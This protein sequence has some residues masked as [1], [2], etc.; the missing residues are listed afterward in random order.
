MLVAFPLPPAVRTYRTH[1]P[2]L[3]YTH[4]RFATPHSRITLQRHTVTV[5]LPVSTHTLPRP[6]APHLPTTYL[7]TLVG[8]YYLLPAGRRSG[9]ADWL[10]TIW[11]RSAVGYYGSLD[12]L[13]AGSTCTCGRSYAWL[14]AHY[15]LRLHYA[16]TPDWTAR[17]HHCLP[18]GYV[19]H[20]ARA[21]LDSVARRTV[22]PPLRATVCA[23]CAFW[24]RGFMYWRSALYTAHAAGLRCR[25]CQDLPV[26]GLP[27]S[28]AG[29]VW[30]RLPA[31]FTPYH[32]LAD[33][34]RF[35]R[36]PT[37][38]LAA[39]V[40]CQ[41]CSSYRLLYGWLHSCLRTLPA[42]AYATYTCLPCRGPPLPGRYICY[43]AVLLPACLC[44][45]PTACLPTMP[46]RHG[47]AMVK[48]RFVH[49]C[50]PACL[51]HHR[52]R[53]AR[54]GSGLD[55]ACRTRFALDYPVH[56]IPPFTFTP[57]C[58]HTPT[59]DGRF[60]RLS[61]YAYSTYRGLRLYTYYTAH[62]AHCW[63]GQF[64]RSGRSSTTLIHHTSLHALPGSTGST[65]ND[66]RRAFLQYATIPLPTRLRFTRIT[67]YLHHHHLLRL[68]CLYHRMHRITAL[69]APRS[70]FC[71]PHCLHYATPS[72]FT[73]PLPHLPTRGCRSRLVT[74]PHPAP[75][76]F[77]PGHAFCR[78]GRS[79]LLPLPPLGSGSVCCT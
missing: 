1:L 18:G 33:P 35:M 16:A 31:R 25:T 53:A 76:P 29:C 28:H 5:Q 49:T 8:R 50:L 70:A 42:R 23:H 46:V 24:L 72:P 62:R 10:R 41:R 60:T 74:V 79:T 17:I 21:V 48:T 59:V 37:V 32:L 47:C 73:T 40:R 57:V 51:C 39:L 56:C 61:Y 4:I 26:P 3:L 75:F 9:L 36:P 45:L 54:S 68:R 14:P 63:T 66:I 7:T 44:V 43:A 77:H 71:Y 27:G 30:L 12:R 69:H 34:L 2:H 6:A 55:A 13:R 64:A 65:V 20:T 58:C 15:T 38:Y 22:L 11:F 52:I 19:R 67:H 78:S